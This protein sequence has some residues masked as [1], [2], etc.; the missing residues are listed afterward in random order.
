MKKSKKSLSRKASSKKIIKPSATSSD[1]QNLTLLT[2]SNVLTTNRNNTFMTQPS[3]SV[4][5]RVVNGVQ[6]PHISFEPESTIRD[7]YD[8]KHS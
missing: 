6:I 4:K 2:S 7:R 5:S 8:L 3:G 1:N